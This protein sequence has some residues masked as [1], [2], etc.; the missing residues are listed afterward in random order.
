IRLQVQDAYDAVRVARASLATAEERV[1]AAS[2][3]FRLTQRRVAEGQVNQ[4]AFVDA[5]TAL[6]S[7]ELN[8]NVTRYALLARLA[9][10]EFAV[11]SA[12][13]E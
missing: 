11:G 2:E 10:L 8:L 9:D 7:A 4:V 1:A 12:V 3:G 6:T 13:L 5:R